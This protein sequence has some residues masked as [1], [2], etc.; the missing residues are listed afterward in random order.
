MSESIVSP[1]YYLIVRLEI[2]SDGSLWHFKE[3]G[4]IFYNPTG[5][6]VRLKNLPEQYGLTDRAVTI[7][8]FRINGGKAG[9]YL[10]N[11]RDR[12]YYYCGPDWQDVRAKLI[13]LGIGCKD[14][15]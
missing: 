8:L 15:N 13:S 3:G 12:Q 1:I 6:K 9:Y 2:R 10:A 5:K 7:E 11:L 14:P 4:E